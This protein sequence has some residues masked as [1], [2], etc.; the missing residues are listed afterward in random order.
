MHKKDEGEYYL[1]KTH[2]EQCNKICKP[3]YEN[4]KEI[5]KEIYNYNKFKF[6]LIEYLNKYPTITYT[7]FR[8]LALQLYEAN[9]CSFNVQNYTLSN[10]YYN[11]RKPS[12][13]FNKFS[14]FNNQFTNNNQLYLR[15]YIHKSIYNKKGNRLINYEHI[16]HTSNYFIR[17]LRESIHYYIDG[18]FVRPKG[19]VQMIVF[20]YYDNKTQKRYPGAFALI[21]NRTE[22]G[23][24]ELFKSLF[25]Y[26]TIEKY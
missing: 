16:I 15:E 23:Y 4:Y 22:Q 12:N 8:K 25:N 1:C 21:N 5:N 13:L 6:S 24:K 19:F 18:T 17:K 7:K 9:E 2:S 20:L 11:W 14:I 26:I 10:I 3:L